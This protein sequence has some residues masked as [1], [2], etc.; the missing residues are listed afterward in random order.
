[1]LHLKFKFN[2]KFA[3]IFL[4]LEL[5]LELQIMRIY[6]KALFSFETVLEL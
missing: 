3:N 2:L 6:F 1:M 5:E 4:E